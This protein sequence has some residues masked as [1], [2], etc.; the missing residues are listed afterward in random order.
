V[1]APTERNGSRKPDAAAVAIWAAA[2]EAEPPSTESWLDLMVNLRAGAECE[3]H[4]PDDPDL[5]P[6][7]AFSAHA[8]QCIWRFL[9]QQPHFIREP[10]DIVPLYRL[11]SAVIDLLRGQVG[12]MFKPPLKNG[13]GCAPEITKG[14]AARALDELILA[15]EPVASATSRVA[16]ACGN[17]VETVQN[18][19]D[20]LHRKPGAG[21]PKDGAARF[22]YEKKLSPEMGITHRE[23]ADSLIKDLQRSAALGV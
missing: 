14:T 23:R 4:T 9:S 12:P 11:S 3:R 15:G 20:R 7:L 10:A 22:A 5:P 1:S 17:T 21:A 19:R 8:V 13:N 16:R 18:W 2:A 6:G